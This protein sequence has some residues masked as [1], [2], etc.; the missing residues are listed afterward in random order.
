MYDWSEIH[1]ARC[2]FH[3]GSDWLVEVFKRQKHRFVGGTNDKGLD[4]YVQKGELFSRSPLPLTF[5][6][7]LSF[8]P[9]RFIFYSS[10]TIFLNI[11]PLYT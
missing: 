3:N 9:T 10:N 4:N 11:A 1:F 6:T 2:L 7:L 8:K 5:K